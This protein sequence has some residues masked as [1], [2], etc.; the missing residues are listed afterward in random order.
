VELDTFHADVEEAKAKLDRLQEKLS[1]VESQKKEVT[2]VV[3]DAERRIHM[4]KNSTRAE[5]FKLKDELETLQRLHMWKATKVLPELFEFTYASSYCV[6]IPCINFRPVVADIQI[7]RAENAQAKHKEV[8][9]LLSALVL[10][11][12]NQLVTRHGAQGIREIVQ[13]LGDYWSSCSQLQA[14]LKLVSIKFPLSIEET[15]AGFSATAT[16][17]FPNLKAKALISF[18]LDTPIFSSWPVLIQSIRCD[19]KVAYGPIDRN[20]IKNAVTARLQQASPINSHACMLDACM[21]AM[22]CFA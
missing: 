15:P 13:R 7:K 4:Q 17:L 3:D 2:S 18:I 19:V 1:E 20:T 8:S 14:Q 12:A 22:E 21:E 5:I 16:I 10:R 6:S 11:T 9:P